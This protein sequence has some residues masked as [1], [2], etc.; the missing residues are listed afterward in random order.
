[1]DYSGDIM[2]VD[3]DM[4]IIKSALIY[5]DIGD[6]ESLI[7]ARIRSF[8]LLAKHNRL[9]KYKAYSEFLHHLDDLLRGNVDLDQFKE[10]VGN[11]H[12]IENLLEGSAGEHGYLPSLFYLLQLSLDRYNVRYPS[13]DMKRCD[14][15]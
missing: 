5:G 13:Y 7:Q 6:A 11:I 12:G 8:K 14:D 4:E 15:L 9:G 3:S 1:M 10:S 2:N